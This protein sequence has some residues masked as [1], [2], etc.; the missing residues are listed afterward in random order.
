[1]LPSPHQ[2]RE[3]EAIEGCLPI[4]DSVQATPHKRFAV[5]L[6]AFYDEFPPIRRWAGM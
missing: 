5:K 4:V 1:M 2:G 3:Q 6:Q